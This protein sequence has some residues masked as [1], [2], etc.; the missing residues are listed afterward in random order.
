M[1]RLVKRLR[2]GPYAVTIG[3]E[4]RFICGCGLSGALPFCDATHQ[5]TRTEEPGKLHWYDAGQ[6]RHNAMDGF[7]DIRSDEPGKARLAAEVV[8]VSS[9]FASDR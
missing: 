3:G 5:I 6:R 7:P 8:N 2:N 1:T 4:T 9:Q